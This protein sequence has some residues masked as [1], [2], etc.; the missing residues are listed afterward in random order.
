VGIA[1]EYAMTGV[2]LYLHIG[3]HKTGTSAL[4]H[5][6][7]H[8]QEILKKSGWLYPTTGISS[9]HYGHHD[10]AWHINKKTPFTYARL[11]DEI[12][13][14]ACGNVILSSEEFEFTKTPNAVADFFHAFNTRIIVYFRRQDEFLLSEFNQNVKMGNH[15]GGLL[16]FATQMAKHGRLDYHAQ[17][18]KWATVFG[19]TSVLARIYGKKPSIEQ[20]FFQALGV[21][22]SYC[23][24][25][26]HIHS[27]FSLDARLIGT[28]R[29]LAQLKKDSINPDYYTGLMKLTRAVKP[30]TPEGVTYSLMSQKEQVEFLEAYRESNHR[31]S[32]E[33]LGGATFEEPRSDSSM[34][35]VGEGFVSPD[36]FKVILRSLEQI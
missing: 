30:F 19:K 15:G 33:Y 32:V 12:E 13:A 22:G 34:H 2:N 3:T 20:V 29:A 10:I 36:A 7:L 21:D 8:N 27:N 4:Q 31:L 14:S 6:L 28:M 23:E 26:R 9:N 18:E 1:L 35:K 25:P 24:P 5:Y 17:C 16:A 11:A